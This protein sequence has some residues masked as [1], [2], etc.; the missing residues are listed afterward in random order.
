L[1]A[2]IFAFRF[3][4]GSEGLTPERATVALFVDATGALLEGSAEAEKLK[5]GKINRT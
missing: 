3:A 5:K 1:A 2:R 4:P